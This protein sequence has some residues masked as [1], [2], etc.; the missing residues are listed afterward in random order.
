MSVPNILT[1]SRVILLPLFF[2]L[3]QQASPVV[4]AILLPHD[5]DLAQLFGLFGFPGTFITVF[6]ETVDFV[7]APD[8]A[9]KA[10]NSS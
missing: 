2:Y 6:G 9:V 3:Y 10:D 5:G 4:S 8:W 1:I 7:R